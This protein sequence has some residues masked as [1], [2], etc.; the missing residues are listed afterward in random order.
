MA[1]VLPRY[2][3]IKAYLVEAIRGRE[4]APGE[5]IPAELALAERFGVSRMTANKAINELVAEGY[6]VRHQ[7]MGT[8]VAEIRA[9]SPLLQI[10]NIADE[11]RE[12]QHVHNAELHRL[13]AVEVDAEL[14][15]R[16]GMTVGETAFHSLIV[17]REN[18]VPIQL[19]DR[20]VN[21][22]IAPDYL[23]QDFRR[24]TPNQ[25][26]SARFPLSQV[27]HIV[28]AVAADPKLTELL[29]IAPNEPCLQVNRRTWSDNRLISCARLIHPGSRY[30]LA[31]RT[32]D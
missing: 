31:A 21:A 9:E 14:A 30:R 7:G 26:L 15:I 24:Q 16:L 27:E 1:K 13:E 29:A 25:F 17:H 32:Q 5:Q 11:I 18:G 22:A 12:R 19:E 20:Y 28:E 2:K 6:L 4:F 3:A 23:E 8:F 10:R